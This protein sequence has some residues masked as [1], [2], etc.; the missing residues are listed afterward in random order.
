MIYTPYYLPIHTFEHL[1]INSYIYNM[2][3]RMARIAVHFDG[4]F[5]ESHNYVS[6][7]VYEIQLMNICDIKNCTLAL[8]PS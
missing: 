7:S 1:V 6:F 4:F 3:V 2:F 8:D 5:N